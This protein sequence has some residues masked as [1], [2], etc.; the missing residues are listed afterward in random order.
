VGYILNYFHTHSTNIFAVQMNT[1]TDE[2]AAEENE[3]RR[4]TC[5]KIA[6]A[7]RRPSQSR[8]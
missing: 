2:S 7:G 1:V 4:V 3:D 6:E 5:D 8:R